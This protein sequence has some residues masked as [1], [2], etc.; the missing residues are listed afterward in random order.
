LGIVRSH[1]GAIR[2]DSAPGKGTKFSVIFPISPDDE[3]ERELQGAE[4]SARLANAANTPAIN[5]STANEAVETPSTTESTVAIGRA[6]LIVDDDEAVLTIARTALE[7]GGYRALT[8]QSGA[9]ALRHFTAHQAEIVA[10]LADATMPDLG[11]VEVLRQI[12][13]QAPN[14]PLLL[15]SGYTENAYHQTDELRLAGFVGKP[16][17]IGEL[18]ATIDAAVAPD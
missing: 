9:E 12:R 18:A 8:A 5:A 15:M 13:A 10:V 1:G 2:V 4:E 16:F 14:L 17:R 7:R 11:G 3:D 6:V